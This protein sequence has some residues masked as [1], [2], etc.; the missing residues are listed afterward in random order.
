MFTDILV[1]QQTSY[2][3]AGGQIQA[4]GPITVNKAAGYYAVTLPPMTVT[5]PDG[6]YQKFG[7]TAINASPSNKAGEWKMSVALPST[8]SYFDPEDKPV[9]TLSVGTQKMSGIWDESEGYFTHYDGT[10]SNI[11]MT[12]T[13]NAGFSIGKLVINSAVQ[14]PRK[15]GELDVVDTAIKLL[16]DNFLPAS[17]TG[18]YRDVIPSHIALDV[19]LKNT[20]YE[21]LAKLG[22]DTLTSSDAGGQVAGLAF[23]NFLP[24]ILSQ[25][26]TQAVIR[27]SKFGN[28]EYETSFSGTVSASGNPQSHGAVGNIRAE[29]SG[30]NGMI[31]GFQQK[32]VATTPEAQKKYTSLVAQMTLLAAM[33]QAGKNAAGKDIKIYDFTLG[34][35]GQVLLNGTD[36][37]A[38][39]GMAQPKA[40]SSAAH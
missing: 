4:E 1:R 23:I 17:D 18:L 6:R 40:D 9:M 34:E 14:P 38:L 25:A 16:I 31:A 12:G 28:G 20:P 29:I 2:A 24:Q 22:G 3:E 21:K 19:T 35:N 5:A 15:T 33:G 7:M 39:F 11:K 32:A 26:G 30:L 27:P 37:G 8:I 36:F 13:G 10:Y